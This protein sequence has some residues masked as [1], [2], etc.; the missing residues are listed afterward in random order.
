MINYRVHSFDALKSEDKLEE[1]QTTMQK[2]HDQEDAGP[3]RR[4]SSR[5]CRAGVKLQATPISFHRANKALTAVAV[6][7]HQDDLLE[8]VRWRVVDHAV[9][10][11]QD[12]RQGLVHKDEDHGDLGKVLWVGQLLTSVK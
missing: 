9:D 10:G 3:N 4:T 5:K 1:E 7:I 8:Q 12:H 2:Q 11:A 6:V